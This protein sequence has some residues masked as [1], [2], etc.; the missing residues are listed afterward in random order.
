M[1][2]PPSGIFSGSTLLRSTTASGT[3]SSSALIV[4]ST[5]SALLADI[6]S[7]RPQL[8][9]DQRRQLRR[10]VLGCPGDVEALAQLHLRHEQEHHDRGQ[11]LSAAPGPIGC[12]SKAA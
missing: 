4:S 1:I 9:L 8:L 2:S 12:A 11:V 5:C 6:V 3:V 7:L 10:P